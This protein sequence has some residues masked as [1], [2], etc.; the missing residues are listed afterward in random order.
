MVRKLLLALCLTFALTGCSA[1]ER[2]PLRSPCVAAP[3]TQV[4]TP[5]GRHPVNANWLS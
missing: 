5:C 4:D 2:P 3:S 1:K